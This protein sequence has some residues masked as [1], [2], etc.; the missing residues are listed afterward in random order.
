MIIYCCQ[1]IT[2]RAEKFKTSFKDDLCTQKG[3]NGMAKVLGVGAEN[4]DDYLLQQ[5]NKAEKKIKK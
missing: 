3:Q 1:S 2:N 5:Q 4:L